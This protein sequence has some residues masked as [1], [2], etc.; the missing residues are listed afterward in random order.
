MMEE[1]RLRDAAN[2]LLARIDTEMS[3]PPGTPE[4]YLIGGLTR[5]GS[6]L[7][8]LLRAALETVCAEQRVK[9]IEYLPTS[10]GRH[11]SLRTAMAGELARALQDAAGSYG[12]RARVLV[13]DLRNPRSILRRVM[14]MRNKAAHEGVIPPDV[15]DAG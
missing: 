14:D 13:G 1:T 6:K 10:A 2:E 5:I 11:R 4:T 3:R 7:E 9:A 12:G 15:S 8:K